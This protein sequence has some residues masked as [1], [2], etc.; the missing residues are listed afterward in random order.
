M[1]AGIDHKEDLWSIKHS[2]S[3]NRCAIALF[4]LSLPR[5]L[6]HLI[7]HGVIARSDR[8]LDLIRNQRRKPDVVVAW[9]SRIDMSYCGIF[10]PEG[11]PIA[12]DYAINAL[13]RERRVHRRVNIGPPPSCQYIRPLMKL[14]LLGQTSLLGYKNRK[15]LCA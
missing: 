12:A 7:S 6:S 3:P 9:R 13:F 1:R 11:R 5:A 10:Q 15:I 14:L 4:G 8:R 2:K